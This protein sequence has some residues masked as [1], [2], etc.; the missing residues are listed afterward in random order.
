MQKGRW[1]ALKSG[2]PWETIPKRMTDQHP[3][4]NGLLLGTDDGDEARI[5]SGP[6]Y[7]C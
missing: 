1:Y 5:R 7:C 3:L 2:T 6:G 4:W